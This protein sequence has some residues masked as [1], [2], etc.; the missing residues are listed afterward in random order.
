M[1]A[2]LKLHLEVLY[3]RIIWKLKKKPIVKSIDE[4]LDYI[5]EHH[6][7]VSRYGDGEFTVILGK[8]C[9]EYQ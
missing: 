3:N 2:K 8:N 4:T 5:N 1:I 6:C 7:S 9:T